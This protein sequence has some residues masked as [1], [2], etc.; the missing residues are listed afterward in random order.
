MIRGGYTKVF[1]RVGVGLANNFDEGF[2][3]GMSTTISSPFGAPYET[4]PAVRFIEPDQLPPTVPAAP[5]GGFPQTPP[6]QA[7]IITQSIDDT[8]VTPSAHM[9]SLVVG[10]DLSTQLRDRSRLRR[11]ASVATCWCGATSAMPLN[12]TDPRS[13]MDYF[14]AVQTLIRARAGQRRR[15]ASARSRTGRTCSRRPPAAA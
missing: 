9:V 11:A 10:R 12:L 6:R 2:A 5:P 15:P 4:D 1:D 13:G 8:L 14:T 7:G 3:F